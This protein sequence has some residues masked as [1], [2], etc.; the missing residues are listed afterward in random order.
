MGGGDACAALHA[1]HAVA[2]LPPALRFCAFGGLGIWGVWVSGFDARAQL[3]EQLHWV[4][5]CS[6]TTRRQSTPLQ[7]ACAGVNRRQLPAVS[8]PLRLLTL[9][10]QTQRSQLDPDSPSLLPRRA[11]AVP[12]DGKNYTVVEQLPPGLSLERPIPNWHHPRAQ[13]LFVFYD[14][15]V[16]RDL[17]G[18]SFHG[19][20]QYAWDPESAEAVKAGEP[21]GGGGGWRA[22]VACAAVIVAHFNVRM[23]M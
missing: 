17:G 11:R 9:S 16:A 8:G 2:S 12:W 7:K 20:P 18:T 13:E 1:T 10:A 6:P 4:D 14:R 3:A 23:S 19:D 5:G 21:R 15:W 22:P